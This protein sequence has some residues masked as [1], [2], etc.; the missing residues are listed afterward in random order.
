MQFRTSFEPAPNQLRTGSEPDSVGLM[1]LAANLLARAS[2]LLASYMIG[3]I[4]ART[5]SEPASVME[6][7]FYYGPLTVSQTGVKY[8]T[9]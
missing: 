5:S 7:G 6:F 2:S 1:D 8:F 3:Q 9:R 4:S